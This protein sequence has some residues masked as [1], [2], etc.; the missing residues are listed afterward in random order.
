MTGEDQP[1]PLIDVPPNDRP[2]PEPKNALSIELAGMVASGV[3]KPCEAALLNS[4]EESD[5]LRF[6]EEEETEAEEADD[7][8]DDDSDYSDDESSSWDSEADAELVGMNAG[9]LSEMMKMLNHAKA[10]QQ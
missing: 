1:A 6:E 8:S 2:C 5:I 3:M 10:K 7:D 4:M 9:E